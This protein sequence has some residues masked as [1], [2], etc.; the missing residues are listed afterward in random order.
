MTRKHYTVVFEHG[1]RPNQWVA[2]VKEIPQCHTFGRGLAQVRARIREALALWEGDEAEHADLQEVLPLP[3]T[4]RAKLGKLDALRRKMTA[5]AQTTKQQQDDV[6]SDLLGEWSLRD[7]GSM[8]DL[9]H[10][11]VNQI[12]VARGKR[13]KRAAAGAK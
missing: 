8:L 13:T 6:V 1:D 3:K 9:S 5:L 2:F 11:R 10:Q 12:A 7:I 4:T